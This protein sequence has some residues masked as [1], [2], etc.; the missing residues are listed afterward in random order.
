MLRLHK[1]YSRSL[2]GVINFICRRQCA[3]KNYI[4]RIQFEVSVDSATRISLHH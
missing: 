3:I 2:G 4:E 1:A